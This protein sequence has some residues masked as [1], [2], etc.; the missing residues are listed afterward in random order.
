MVV[1]L[2]HSGS[3]IASP[4]TPEVALIP[5]V[6]AEHLEYPVCTRIP[7]RRNVKLGTE[8]KKKKKKMGYV[9]VN[10]KITCE[11]LVALNV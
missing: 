10:Q 6:R 1:Q 11:A 9:L 3:N 7:R 2:V 5:T 8:K 4:I